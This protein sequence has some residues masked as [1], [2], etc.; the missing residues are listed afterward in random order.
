MTKKLDPSQHKAKINKLAQEAQNSIWYRIKQLQTREEKIDMIKEGNPLLYIFG[1][2]L[3][4]WKGYEDY[5]TNLNR[6]YL[7][8]IKGE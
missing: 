4:V 8:K 3:M 1:E 6:L 2:F 7:G 5:E